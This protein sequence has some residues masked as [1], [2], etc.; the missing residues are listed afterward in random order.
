MNFNQKIIVLARGDQQLLC[1]V[2]KVNMRTSGRREDDPDSGLCAGVKILKVPEQDGA[3]GMYV[4]QGG[5]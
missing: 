4:H 2:A 1:F 5:W 3:R